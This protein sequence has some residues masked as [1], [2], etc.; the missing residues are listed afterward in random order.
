[1]K[2]LIYDKKYIGYH[3]FTSMVVAIMLLVEDILEG[4]T[5]Y[6]AMIFE[7][8][9][10]IPIFMV[11]NLGISI[12]VFFII[13]YL[14]ASVPWQNGLWK[15]F[16]YEMAIMVALVLMMTIASSYLVRTFELMPSDADGDLG[17]EILSLIMFFIS[18]FMLFSFHEFI[19]LSQDK[20]YLSLRASQLEK[21]NYLMKYEALK[22]QVNPH[23]LFNSLNVLSSLIY[24]DTEKS[25]Q[26]I[27]KFSEVFRYVLELNNEKLVTVKRELDF[28][29]AYCF[30]QKIR[31]GDSLLI[32]RSLDAAVLERYIPPLTLQLVVENT[33]KHNEISNERKLHI[34][35]TNTES[36]LFISNNY[37]HRGALNGSM[38]VGQKNLIE[39]YRL[40]A[41]KAPRFYL[42]GGQYIAQLP[43]LD[44]THGQGFDY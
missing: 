19:N 26:F 9:T 20:E 33:V 36:H 1:M 39:K 41:D 37:Q 2:A 25:D 5:E 11:L 31:Y 15:R 12:G 43:L 10:D 4:E 34:S 22:T 24:I 7:F 42:E 13:R 16:L 3:L 6:A 21:Q 17:F 38:G 40:L 28:L 30:L 44:N 29:D 35:I 18:I 8:V 27:K 32:N 14:N 23:F